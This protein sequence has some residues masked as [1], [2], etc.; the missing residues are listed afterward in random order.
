MWTLLCPWGLALCKDRKE[1]MLLI[2][3]SKNS[4]GTASS[5]NWSLLLRWGQTG[6]CRGVAAWTGFGIGYL[7]Q[8]PVV[9]D[10]PHLQKCSWGLVMMTSCWGG[11]EVLCLKT[12]HCGMTGQKATACPHALWGWHD[13]NGFRGR[14]KDGFCEHFLGPSVIALPC[15]LE[16]R[17][18]QVQRS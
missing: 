12:W 17:Q 7:H 6:V 8:E 9:R 2:I 16:G 15:P 13:D 3:G 18:D 11:A 1:I 4:R 14:L 10:Q 5:S